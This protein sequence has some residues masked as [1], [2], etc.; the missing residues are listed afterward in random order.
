MDG[1]VIIDK[2]KNMTSHDVVNIARYGLKTK[3]IGHTG[4]LDPNATGVLVL[5][6]GKAT[7][8]VKYF[9]SDKKTYL[10]KILIG[11]QFDTDD[12]TGTLI[13]QKDASTISKDVLINAIESFSGK[14]KQLPPDYSAIKQQGKKLYE[15][16]RKNIAINNVDLR[17]IE[18]KKI[19][20]IDINYH[21]KTIE[22]NLEIEVSKGTYIRSIA[23]DLGL[24]L[25]NYGVLVE[26]RRTAVNNILIE[27]SHS[28]T[29]L[30]NGKVKIKNAFDYL[31]LQK[32]IID[33]RYFDYINNGRYLS[34]EIFPEKKDSII[35]TQDGQVLAIYYYDET[36]NQMRM[37]VKWC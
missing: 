8:L 20:I 10:A 28:I 32:V 18:I 29:D 7:K 19:Q 31:E 2:E 13:N 16:A 36:K 11:Q 27:D 3:K 17:D 24:K 1:I 25:N 12:I 33:D 5:C 22:I 21:E 15:L 23:R 14:Q 34:T 26:L 37:S 30:R 9:A 35:Y 4:T 6:V